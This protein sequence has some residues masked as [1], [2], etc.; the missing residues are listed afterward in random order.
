MYADFGQIALAIENGKAPLI[1][2]GSG[3]RVYDLGTGF[4]AKVAKN[5]RG[6]AQNEAEYHIASRDTSGLFARVSAVSG[7]YRT[8]VMERAERIPDIA[9]VW[10]YFHIRD[11]HG[12]YRIKPLRDASMRYGLIMGD[13]GRCQNWGLIGSRPVV[14]DYGF[15]QW[16][17]RRFYHM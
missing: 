8:L 3:R 4:V 17:R 12:L 13:L 7:D 11:V 15:T 14:I 10:E 1:G 6:V 5:A 16:V 9:P 2:S